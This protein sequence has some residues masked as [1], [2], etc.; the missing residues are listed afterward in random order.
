VAWL[1]AASCA[2]PRPVDG[3]DRPWSPPEGWFLSGSSAAQF[4]AFRDPSVVHG[5]RASAR[6]EA[7]HGGVDGVATLMQSL[8]PEAYRGKRVRFSGFVATAG[9]TGWTG[10]WMRVDRP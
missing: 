9:V 10:L 7:L 4:R 3:D 6:L 1:V 8:S 5:G 2:R